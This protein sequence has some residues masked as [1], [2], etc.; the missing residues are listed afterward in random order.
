M[1]CQIPGGVSHR[2]YKQL[3]LAVGSELVERSKAFDIFF[4]SP[5]SSA[6]GG[7]RLSQGRKEK[8]VMSLVL[9]RARSSGKNKQ[10]ENRLRA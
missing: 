5:P 8:F 2:T 1:N 6:S 10:A 9:R 3:L 7:G 4:C